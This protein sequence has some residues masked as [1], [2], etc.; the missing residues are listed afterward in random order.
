M[1]ATLEAAGTRSC[2]FAVAHS[3]AAMITANVI[4]VFI[5][6]EA[7]GPHAFRNLPDYHHESALEGTFG[8]ATG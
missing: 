6:L 8:A 3:A 4:L 5:R 2:P 7:F 1:S